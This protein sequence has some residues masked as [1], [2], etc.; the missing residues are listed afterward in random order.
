[1]MHDVGLDRRYLNLVIFADQI[2]RIVARKGAAAIL[3]NRRRVIAKRIGIIGQLPVVRL[4]P[5]LCSAGPRILA[6]L[7]FVRRRRLRRRARILIGALKPKQQLVEL[8]FTELLQINP[9][10]PS[11]D[12]EIATLGKGVDNCAGPTPSITK[13]FCA[14]R[15]YGTGAVIIRLWRLWSARLRRR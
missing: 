6:L 8:L 1:M 12:S 14:A 11:M 3:A 9:L 15:V 5:E 4:V 7:L 2:A 10:H 13:D